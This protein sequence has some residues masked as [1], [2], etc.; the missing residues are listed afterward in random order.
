MLSQQ[1]LTA[2]STFYSFFTLLFMCIHKKV[3]MNEYCAGLGV[4]YYTNLF[5][6]RITDTALCWILCESLGRMIH[7]I[8]EVFFE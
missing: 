7:V 3:K 5:S 2:T 8:N 1:S 6:E 4:R